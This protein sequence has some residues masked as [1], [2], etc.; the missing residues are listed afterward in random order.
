MGDLLLLLHMQ[1][2]SAY[3]SSDV[4]STLY[5]PPTTYIHSQTIDASLCL[6]DTYTTYSHLSDT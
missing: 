6:L 3:V 5:I 4:S 1:Y 2:V